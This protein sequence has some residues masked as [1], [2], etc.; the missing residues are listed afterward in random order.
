[1]VLVL[2]KQKYKAGQ[3]LDPDDCS[4]AEKLILMT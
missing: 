2:I 4:N 1:M 3:L